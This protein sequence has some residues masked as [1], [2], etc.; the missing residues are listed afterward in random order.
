MNF[1]ALK[2]LLENHGLKIVKHYGGT[3]FKFRPLVIID[4]ILSIIYP[5]LSTDMIVV[6][7]R[8]K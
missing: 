6:A 4:M 5:R 3:A 1:W 8:I 7:E 2:E